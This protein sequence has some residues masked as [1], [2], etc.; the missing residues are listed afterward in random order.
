MASGNGTNFK[1]ILERIQDGSLKAICGVLITNNSG[2]GAVKIAEEFQIPVVHLSQKTHPDPD[3]YETALLNVLKKYGIRAIIL[4]GYMKALPAAVIHAYPG[5]I[6]N[7]HPSLL[8]KYGG[9]GFYGDRVHQAVID[10]GDTVSGVTVHLVTENYDEGPVLAR[11]EAPVEKSDTAET[12]AEKI[13]KVEHDFY[14]RVL[15]EQ[16]Q[17]LESL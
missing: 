12:L 1:A 2:S 4:A 14:F 8:P 3:N 17:K 16:F 5:R 13:H 11:R 15:A 7:I 10:A 6:F 9:A